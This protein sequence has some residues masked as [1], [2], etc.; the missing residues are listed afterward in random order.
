VV[1]PIKTEAYAGGP[2]RQIE[3]D[4]VLQRN[5]SRGVIQAGTGETGV[6]YGTHG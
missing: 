2:M 1:L 3:R 6:R 5:H 4:G